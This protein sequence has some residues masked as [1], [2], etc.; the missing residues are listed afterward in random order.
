MYEKRYER[1]LAQSFI[2]WVQDSIQSGNRYLFKSPDIN[3]SIDL[4]NAFVNIARENFF[5]VNN[6][7]F[8]FIDCNG[9]RLVPVLQ[10]VEKGYFS[11]NFISYLRDEI[12][13]REGIFNNTALLI[14]HNSMLDTLIN[15]ALDVT[16]ANAIWNPTIFAKKL[17]TH[18]DPKSETKE[19]TECLLDDQLSVIL[20]EG[21]T[22]FGLAPLFEGLEDGQLAFKELGLFD[23]PLLLEYKQQPTQIRRRI[24]E[25]RTLRKE[26]EFAV[27]HYPEQ[28]EIKLKNFSSRF[29]KEHFIDKKDWHILTFDEYLK[30]INTNKSQKLFLEKIE[31]E[32]ADFLQRAKSQTKSGQK[33]ISLI[34]QV[35]QQR[36]KVKL[37]FTFAGN[38]LIDDEL[39][40][41]HN[42]YLIKNNEIKVSRTGGKR[43]WAEIILPFTGNDP[44]FFSLELKRDNR[45]EEYK[46]C[47]V[48]VR[49]QQFYFTYIK[50]HYRVEPSKNR[51]TILLEDNRIRISETLNAEDNNYILEKNDS[52]ID[53]NKYNIVDFEQF[54][55][56]TEFVQFTLRSQDV[57]LNLNI[58][59]PD[60]EDTIHI[61]LLF[62]K[63]R[64]K[65]LFDDNYY[66]EYNKIRGKI[67]IDNAESNTSGIRHQLLNF[68][69][70]MVD[71]QLLSVL[72]N[73]LLPLS[74]L[75]ISFPELYNAYYA[76]FCYLKKR[77]STPSLVSWGSEYRYLV[78]VVINCYE[79]A[80]NNIQL[81]C[82]LSKEY[83]QLLQIGLHK[84]DNFERISPLH[85]LILSY[86]LMLVQQI[87]KDRD[88][89]GYSSFTELP[90]ITLERLVASGLIPFLF[91]LESD[92]SHVLPVKDNP[93]WLDI[94]PQRQANYPYVKR[95]V[96][97]KINEFS[98]SYS[99]L[100]GAGVNSTLIINAINQKKAKELFFGIIDYFKHHKQLA[101]AIHINFY[102]SQLTYN[103]F[104]YFSETIL[105]DELKE[106]LSLNTGVWRTE[107]NLLIDIIRNRLTYSK[108]V[109]P[110]TEQS[111]AYAHLA[112]FS[113]DIPVDCRDVKIENALSGVLCDGLIAGEASENKEDSYF[114]AF[115]LRD[116]S[117]EDNQS[118]R[119][120]RLIST[121]WKPARQSNTSYSSHG[122]GLA[123]R[124]NFQ[125]LLL[126]SYD[127]ALWT[128]IIDPKVTLDFFTKQ[129]DVVL[130]HY[131]DQYTNSA[132]YDAIT[133]TKQIDLFNLLLDKENSG[134]GVRLLSEFNAFNGEWLLKMLTANEKERK[135]KKGIIA[136]YKFINILLE[137]SDI[138]WIPISVAEMIR[139]SGNVGLKMD[140]SDFS[141]H[142]QGYKKGAISDDVLFVGFKNSQMYL[143]PLEVK[144]GVR[145]DFKHAG[146]QAKE[147]KRYLVKDILG[148][149]NL[150]SRLYRGLFIRQV[151]MQVDKFRLYDVLSE[152]KLSQLLTRRD[153]WLKG[154]YQLSDIPNY[155]DGF[156]LAHIENDSCFDAFCK[157]TNEN[158]LQI[159]LPSSLLFS[160]INANDK[161]RLSQLVKNCKIN[162][163][164][165]L[166][167]FTFE[168]GEGKLVL[169]D[170]VKKKEAEELSLVDDNYFISEPKA[171]PLKVLFGHSVIHN[172]P[173]Y[174]EPTNTARF[175]NTNTGI[176]GTMGTGKTQFTK[177][178][179]TQLI[180]NQKNNVDG[181]SIGILIFDYKSD[182]SDD[183]FINAVGANKFKLFKLPYNPLS[184]YGDTPMLPIHTAAGFSET[185]SRAYGLGKKQQLKLE[186]LILDCYIEFG[187]QTEDPSTWNKTA[188]T[189]E[190]IW[191]KFLLQEKVEEDSLYAALSKLA[192]FKIFE[193]IPEKMTSL[194]DL[195]SGVL[196]I[197]LA[198]YPSEIQNL[199]VALTLDLFYSQMQKNGK[200][201]VNGDY[202]QITKMILVDEADNFMSRDFSSLRK[203]LKEGREYG[204]GVILSTQDLSHFKTGENNYTSYVLTWIIHR[205]SE[206]KNV[207]IKAIFNKDE[208]TEQELL[209][210]TI[211]KLDK[212]YSLYI[213]GDKKIQKI[214]DLAFWELVNNL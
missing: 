187:I 92:F 66:A 79:M 53:I 80:L 159:E 5:T 38:D 195:M 125:E 201:S 99:L 198:G 52:I 82:I 43:C 72:P 174:W 212:H 121:L 60:A 88:E 42:K 91:D 123:V 46:F 77:N 188:P 63:A 142:I 11:E 56:K 41:T 86:H 49:Q 209:M 190:D 140:E 78:Q 182:Y 129:K 84:Q 184:L 186:N 50:N 145:P 181:E 29:I 87:I 95:L 98:H 200:P 151:L 126:Q 8:P 105:D 34:I 18:I 58:E 132:G 65:K 68:E 130:I 37:I 211:R 170:I 115:G 39:R 150:A 205:V 180:H 70:M 176:I 124:A 81:D 120:A 30:E 175:M 48:M 108:F 213:N 103:E 178:V 28:L 36:E 64:F 214:K 157:V 62:D 73:N 152:E 144:T 135:E 206:I 141:R 33:E 59:G 114:T 111:L 24:N 51:L 15:S 136:A 101:S 76:L 207:D 7:N 23:D 13:D 158:I 169:P 183:V 90:K 122:I 113:N 173:L 9:I 117:I 156:I 172:K 153:W 67:V 106:R 35:P 74:D 2:E 154:D 100:F 83:K 194:Y 164:F 96:S 89:E 110:K 22:V 10:G 109:T 6:V 116:V 127:S 4:Y 1:Y 163:E 147:L 45:S 204:V 139:V 167:P 12:S 134:H 162:E 31:I 93:T 177:S 137:Q 128:T 203:I 61:P 189:I 27:E 107:A 44:V 166:K 143:L 202:R 191:Q 25:N 199:I 16:V 131:S 75:K 149:N 57:Q 155:V 26:I 32:D 193:D 161:N 171:V 19:I 148:L 146:E 168:E 71:E 104:D 20:E 94:I 14:I 118:L 197:E 69:S 21:A 47:C 208:K 17:K 138:C 133:V 55:N 179:V 97:D 210:E 40:I 54:I 119:L 192:R 112:F 85:P 165:I 196:V 160:L 102:D 3:K 185:M